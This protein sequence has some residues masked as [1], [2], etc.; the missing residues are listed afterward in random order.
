MGFRQNR[1]RR[2]YCLCLLFLVCIAWRAAAQ[3]K[4]GPVMVSADVLEEEFRTNRIQITWNEGLSVASMTLANFKV[5]LTTSN[6]VAPITFGE[7]VAGNP[8]K[9]I[10]SMGSANWYSRSNYYVIVN[11]IRDAANNVIAP[12]SVI[13]VKWAGLPVG[14]VPPSATPRLSITRSGANGHR[15]SW[16]ANSYNYALEWTT[17]V[18]KVGQNSVAGPWCEVQPLMANPYIVTPETGTH[19]IYRLRR[20][21]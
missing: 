18:T 5:V 2:V 20:T 21:Q 16:P 12:N 1:I 4:S 7:Y 11:N 8:A 15:I 14:P 9:T 3:D 19:R 17:N 6:V 13:G 10:L